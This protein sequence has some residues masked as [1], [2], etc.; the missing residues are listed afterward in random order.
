MCVCVLHPVYCAELSLNLYPY[1]PSVIVYTVSTKTKTM[2]FYLLN[3]HLKQNVG[4][5]CLCTF[6]VM[7]VG[8]LSTTNTNILQLYK[9]CG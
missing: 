7:L 3:F 8:F 6:Y 2:E 1:T 4:Y 9:L 5:C